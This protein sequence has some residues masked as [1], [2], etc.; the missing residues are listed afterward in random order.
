MANQAL[1]VTE[2]RFFF[3]WK[4]SGHKF[5][6]NR[7]VWCVLCYTTNIQVYFLRCLQ[8]KWIKLNSRIF[9][10]LIQNSK[11]MEQQQVLRSQKLRENRGY[12]FKQY[13]STMNTEKIG[14]GEKVHLNGFI[15]NT[16]II[17]FNPCSTPEICENR[18][19]WLSALTPTQN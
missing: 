15:N 10:L 3:I 1:L 2:R 12:R 9:W 14:S 8:L 17:S 11:K 16:A 6:L 18:L 4:R 5:R 19:K 7:I 13:L